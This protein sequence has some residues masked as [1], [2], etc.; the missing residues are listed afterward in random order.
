MA[1]DIQTF[2]LGIRNILLG[3]DRSQ[4][5]CIFTR[6]DVE[7][8]LGG[9]YFVMHRPDAQQSKF[10]FW[11]N[12]DNLSTAPTVPNATLVE[13]DIAEDATANAVATATA[14]AIGALA[15]VAAT[16]AGNEVEVLFDDF[17]YAYKARDA[18]A[19][20]SRTRFTIN[21]AQ[22][23]SVEKDLGATSGDITFTIEEQNQEITS[24][25]TGAFVIGEIR[26][27][28]TVSVGFELKDTSDGSIRR[29]IQFYGDTIVTDD[30]ASAVISGYGSA[31]LF[32]STEDVADRLI[33]RPVTRA[34]DEDPSEDFTLHKAKLKLGEITFSAENELVL[35]IEAVGYLDTTKSSFANLFSF[36]DAA[37]LPNA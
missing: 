23:G 10:V 8:S 27:G 37:A 5:T 13:I 2:N 14:A 4:K 7:G 11:Y 20:A 21:V 32:R 3:Q 22:F 31:N 36:G 12:V 33:L 9:K 34:E 35:P 19:E 16:A 30:A 18:L 24:P 6:A 17:G 25:Q 29:A 15:W 28:A 26:R 1:C